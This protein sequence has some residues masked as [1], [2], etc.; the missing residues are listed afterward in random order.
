MP[1]DLSTSPFQSILAPLMERFLGEKRA[2]GYKYCEESRILRHLDDLLCKEC[3][4]SAELPRPITKRWLSKRP[5]ESRSTHQ[6]RITLVRQFSKFLCRLGYPA[7][8][9][10]STL[11]PRG[12]STFVP[13]I[14]THEEVRKLLHAVDHLAPTARSSLRHLVMPEILRLLYGCGFRVGEVLNLRVEDVD[15]K[16]GILTVRQGKFRKDR[17]VPPTPTLVNRLRKY[18]A[19]L[20]SRPAHAVFFPA[21]NGGSYSLRGIYGLFRKLL[22]RCGI[23]HGGRG[24]G[25]RVHDLRHTFAVHTLLRW[26]R[27]GVDPNVKLHILATYLGHENISGTQRYLRL[28]AEFFPEIIR[29]VDMAF[30]DVIPRREP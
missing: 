19:R 17:L 25:P 28:T 8:V 9:P 2:C 4:R 27:E 16:Q 24:K 5:H 7:Y 26:Y 29:R 22:L 1:N 11:A 13:R 10:D 18:S 23:P 21:P 30:G 15:L 12:G 14:L 20:G 6:Q 3:L